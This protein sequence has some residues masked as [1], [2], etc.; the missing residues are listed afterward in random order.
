MNPFYL[1]LLLLLGWVAL[2][3]YAIL[4]F[5]RRHATRRAIGLFLGMTTVTALVVAVLTVGAVPK[6]SVLAALV[7]VNVVMATMFRSCLAGFAL[8]E[9]P[10]N[11]ML[12][13]LGEPVPFRSGRGLPYV[14]NWIVPA[15]TAIAYLSTGDR[16]AE[17][18]CSITFVFS[19]PIFAIKL[20]GERRF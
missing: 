2:Q 9:G 11:H 7:A 13:D 6:W 3:G 16:V 19:L 15:M 8:L 4:S 17:V 14:P 1:V 10:F 12:G 5:F 20:I 18:I